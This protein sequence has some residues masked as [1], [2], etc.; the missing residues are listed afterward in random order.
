[1][2]SLGALRVLVTRAVH[3]APEFSERLRS[4]G[5]DVIE[6]PMVQISPAENLEDLDEALRDM[7]RY[8]WVLLASSNAVDQ[9]FKRAADIGCLPLPVSTAIAVMGPATAEA[10]TRHA[11]RARYHPS[12]YVA[13]AFVKQF[14][15][16]PNLRGQT[17]LWPRSDRGRSLIADEF[18]RAGAEVH[19]VDCYRTSLPD[20]RDTIAAHLAIYL[21]DRRIDVITVASPQ[22]CNN[23]VGLSKSVLGQHEIDDL[24]L[25]MPIVTI[26]PE[27]SSAARKAGFINITQASTYTADGMIEA[28]ATVAHGNH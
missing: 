6:L 9:F 8:Q 22:A 17:M 20:N 21:R 24:L 3:Q 25:Q 10:V 19:A 26:G 7:K 14:P 4:M 13:E 12:Q 15:G 18:T 2:H 16:F 27:T 11:H 28:L 23:L 1:M 5:A